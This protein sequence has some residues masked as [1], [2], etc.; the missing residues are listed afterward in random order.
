MD[1]GYSALSES[2]STSHLPR[3][4]KT[5][6]H[7]SVSIQTQTGESGGYTLKEYTLPVKVFTGHFIYFHLQFS[8]APLLILP[9]SEKTKDHRMIK[10][11]KA[12]IEISCVFDRWRGGL[13]RIVDDSRSTWGG[14]AWP[15]PR[16]VPFRGGCFWRRGGRIPYHGTE[17]FGLQPYRA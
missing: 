13:F 12:T 16:N 17:Y 6:K 11:V 4:Q 10:L 8:F 15:Y 3:N 9:C 5:K 7:A 14:E 2:G 1:S